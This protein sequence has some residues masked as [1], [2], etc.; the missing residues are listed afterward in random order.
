MADDVYRVPVDYPNFGRTVDSP[1]DLDDYDPPADVTREL[2]DLTGV[3]VWGTRKGDGN[4]EHYARTAAGDWLLF[5]HESQYVAV[6]RVGTKFETPWISRTF[7]GY[8]P[9]QL[10]YTI[11]DYRELDLSAA[12]LDDPL[13]LDSNPDPDR[14]RLQRV[15]PDVL[16]DV[17]ERHGSIP[18]FL[19][20]LT[21]K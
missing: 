2:D 10:L 6:G 18:A 7:W 16:A 9:Q 11:E 14:P 8:A 1:V 15:N 4:H 20:A 21:E 17:R 13:D 19:D 3:R 12:D 5:H